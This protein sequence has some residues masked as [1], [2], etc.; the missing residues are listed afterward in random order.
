MKKLDVSQKST[1]GEDAI[2]VWEN[3][4]YYC[5]AFACD[6]AIRLSIMRHDLKDGLT[7]DEIRAVKKDCGFADFDALEFYPKES[8]IVNTGNMRHIFIFEKELPLIWRVKNG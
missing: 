3:A 7:W 5:A 1:F 6:N 8:D 4:T 2:G